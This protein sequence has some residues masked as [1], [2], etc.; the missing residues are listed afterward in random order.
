[1]AAKTVQINQEALEDLLRIKDEF[2]TVVES[3]ELMGNKNFMESYKKAKEE[4]RKRDFVDW[5][6]L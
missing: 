5:N 6:A 4:I 3:I 2:D 1:M